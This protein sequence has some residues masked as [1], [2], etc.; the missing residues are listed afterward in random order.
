MDA[1]GRQWMP[2]DVSQLC[3]AHASGCQCIS[4]DANGCQWMSVNNA[5][6][7]PEHQ[8]LHCPLHPTTT[9]GDSGGENKQTDF[10]KYNQ[11]IP[12][13]QLTFNVLFRI[14]V[15]LGQID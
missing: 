12:L 15:Q 1:I 14:S 2:M 7:M 13:P 5:L 10:T 4:V 6:R 11:Q 8:I 9:T 3:I